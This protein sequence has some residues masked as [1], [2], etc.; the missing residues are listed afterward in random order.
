MN[1]LIYFCF[2]LIMRKVF[3]LESNCVLMVYVFEV[4]DR[5]GRKIYLTSERWKHL[6]LHHPELTGNLEFIKQ[7]VISPSLEVMDKIDGNLYY[8]HY[9]MKEIGFYL[10]VVV[11]YLNKEGFIITA[12]YSKKRKK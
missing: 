11:K 1:L 8:L 9:F 4:V 3:I 12:F 2:C 5:Y 6:S 10:I 7:S